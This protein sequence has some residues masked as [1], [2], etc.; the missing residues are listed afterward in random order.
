MSSKGKHWYNNGKT[1]VSSIEC[2][3]GFS[4]G[5]L[6]VSEETRRRMS[7]SSWTHRASKEDL[8]RRNEAI[9]KTIQSRTE[10]ERQ[11]YSNK[12]SQ[13][14]KG[15]GAGKE[16]WNKGKH[17]EIWNK[18]VPMSEAQKEKLRQAYR[19]LPQ[20]E[21]DKRCARLGATRK[22][23]APWNKGLS[24]SLGPEI[25]KEMKAKEN[26]TKKRNGSYLRTR[27]E[28]RVYDALLGYFEPEL[29]DRKHH[30]ERYPFD[31]D[32]Y[33]PS[34][35][36]YI[37]VNGNWTHGSMPFVE[38]DLT[39]LGQLARWERKAQT[40]DYYK[41]AI[42][43]WTDLDVRKRAIAKDNLLN[44]IC[45]YPNKSFDENASYCYNGSLEDEVFYP[46]LALVCDAAASKE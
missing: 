13:A 20:D 36:L 14:R 23:K 43:T 40:S 15:K 4:K 16:P 12:V 32:F 45:V 30:D 34:L 38:G 39:C 29:I 31:C 2:P 41:N 26:E 37:E 11:E 1:E 42:Y 28:E 19:V 44:Y 46:L 18:G 17:V 7:E 8:A 21:K 22:G 33:L 24:Y 3:D 9:S 5:R 6:K 35:D 27:V 10:A 25:V